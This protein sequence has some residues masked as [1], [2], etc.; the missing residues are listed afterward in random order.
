MQDGYEN[1]T[2]EQGDEF[3]PESAYLAIFGADDL[4]AL[5]LHDAQ[6]EEEATR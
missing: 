1:W 4:A 6:V 2:T 5:E 3:D